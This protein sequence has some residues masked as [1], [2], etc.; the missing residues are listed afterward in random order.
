MDRNKIIFVKE[1]SCNL[2]ELWETL[3]KPEILKHWL[4][5]IENY[6]LKQGGKFSYSINGNILECEVKEVFLYHKLVY[7]MKFPSTKNKSTI[8]FMFHSM[9]NRKYSQLLMKHKKIDALPESDVT[10]SK[11]NLELEWKRLLDENLTI[12]I[13]EKFK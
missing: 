10:F 7:S 12:Y 11:A 8:T 1:Y 9:N 5:G 2:Q 13:N 4:D 3:T 6:D